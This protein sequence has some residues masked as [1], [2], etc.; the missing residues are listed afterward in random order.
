M[1]VG[2]DMTLAIILYSS[3]Q[4]EVITYVLS[5]V[6]LYMYHI[7][8]N[9]ESHCNELILFKNHVSYMF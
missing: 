6:D 1:G 5:Y 4:L 3:L 8:V 2:T 7:H 9:F